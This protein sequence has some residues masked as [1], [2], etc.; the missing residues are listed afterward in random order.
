GGGPDRA[1]G[2]DLERGCGM[3][4]IHVRWLIR[5]DIPEVLEI[6]RR[7]FAD[8]WGGEGFAELLRRRNTI[9]MVAEQS[10]WV[11]GYMVYELRRDRIELLRLAVADDRRREGMGERLVGKL[12]G[13]IAPVVSRRECVAIDVPEP[14]ATLGAC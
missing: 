3:S 9:G 8:R 14:E 5:R 12:K 13:K 11:V 1:G 4:N 7:S 2:G 10:E 6:E